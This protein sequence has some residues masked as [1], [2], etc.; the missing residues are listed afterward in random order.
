[1]EITAEMLRSWGLTGSG[2]THPPPRRG[3]AMAFTDGRSINTGDPT[4]GAGAP[5][6]RGD[7]GEATPT[8]GITNQ[9]FGTEAPAKGF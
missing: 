3:P 5:V 7:L 1:V 2:G 9:G 8:E 4:V 6:T